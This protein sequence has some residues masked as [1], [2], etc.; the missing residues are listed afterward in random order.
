[1]PSEAEWEYACRAGT[2]SR[3]A[4]GDDITWDQVNCDIE[5][6]KTVD[7]ILGIGRREIVEKDPR[8]ATTDVG[9]FRPNAFGLYDMHGNVWE[10]CLDHWHSNYDDDAPIDGNAWIE[11]GDSNFRVYRGGS[12]SS[13]PRFCRSAYRNRFAP[14]S[15]NDSIGFR[16]VL[17]PR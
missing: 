15:R 16:V 10:W 9:S 5:K 1:M 11:E 3:Y 7:G 12:W 14:G 2:S 17:A 8:G 4:F 13:F 6:K